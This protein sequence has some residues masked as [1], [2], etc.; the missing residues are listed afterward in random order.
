MINDDIRLHDYVSAPTALHTEKIRPK[1]EE[2]TRLI[3]DTCS[4]DLM[5]SPIEGSTTTDADTTD[6]V[7]Y[8]SDTVSASSCTREE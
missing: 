3:I 6:D 8:H 7:S 4:V 2:G 1:I 5:A